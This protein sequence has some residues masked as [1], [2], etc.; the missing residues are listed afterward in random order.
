M[1][2]RELGRILVGAVEADPAPHLL[3]GTAG[4]VDAGLMLA[5]AVAQ[6]LSAGVE[7]DTHDRAIR[8]LKGQSDDSPQYDQVVCDAKGLLGDLLHVLGSQWSPDSGPTGVQAYAYVEA[9]LCVERARD[10]LRR[11]AGRQ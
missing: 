5:S 11:A 6:M 9:G 10:H 1:S 8:H 7:L 2:E 3:P 4:E